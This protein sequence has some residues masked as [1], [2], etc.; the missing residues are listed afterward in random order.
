LQYH[1]T[2]EFRDQAQGLL[3]VLDFDGAAEFWVRDLETLQAMMTD[4]EY[5]EKIQPDE[6]N[7]IN[8]ETVTIIIGVDYIVVDNGK[9]V[10]DHAREF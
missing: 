8:G 2:P 9:L 3:P 4:K 10:E 1:S 6:G 5:V 7:F